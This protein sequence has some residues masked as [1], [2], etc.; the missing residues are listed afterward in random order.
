[1]KKKGEVDGDD[2]SND[3][4][5]C[6]LLENT[7]VNA[8]M[9]RER[10]YNRLKFKMEIGTIRQDNEKEDGIIMKRNIKKSI[11][12]AAL[13]CA[14][15]VGG[16]STTAFGQ[17]ITQSIVGY[18]HVGN[19]M[20][21]Q[22]DKELPKIESSVKDDKN[23]VRENTDKITTIKEARA[24]MKINFAVPTWLPDGYK[25][26]KSVMHGD[27]AVELVYSQ[28]QN[29]VSLLI[30][31]G[32]NGISTTGEVK[33]ETIAGKTVYFANGIVLWGQ[34]GLTYELYQMSEQDF[35]LNI[36][37]KIIS[38]LST[39]TDYN[40]K[41]KYDAATKAQ[42]TNDNQI[43]RTNLSN[44]L[45]AQMNSNQGTTE[46]SKET[47]LN[48]KGAICATKETWVDSITHDR[49]RDFKN[50]IYSSS[51]YYVENGTKLSMVGKGDRSDYLNGFNGTTV[52]LSKAADYFKTYDNGFYQ[53]DLFT[54]IK[55]NYQKATWK[56]EGVIKDTDGK[57]LKK[58]SHAYKA[59]E[60][61][62]IEYFFLDQNTG[63]PVKSE[64][65]LENNM[66]I[67]Q[68]SSTFEYKTVTNDG[69]LFDTS[70]MKLKNET[71]TNFEEILSADFGME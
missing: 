8:E 18:V 64:T 44:P 67:R 3:K 63:L 27:N 20:I 65:F 62:M 50:D 7:D 23:A 21:T 71:L 31:K 14:S 58:V 34:D 48:A 52:I 17:E 24:F 30:S 4:D 46:Y 55:D 22:Y 53:K 5:V 16:L 35:D 12:V 36:L 15:L 13:T 1:M 39:G 40:D 59:Q 42:S 61:N 11:A 68:Y 57:E 66:E 60:G 45:N 32:E 69:N 37:G 2:C 43:Q 10:T 25:Y 19:M 51:I 9:H 49:R 56:D 54:A 70:G 33:K 29:L 47:V 41:L 6:R 28:D 26:L 38:T